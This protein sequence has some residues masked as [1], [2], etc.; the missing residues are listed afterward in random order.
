VVDNNPHVVEDHAPMVPPGT[1]VQV[2]PYTEVTELDDTPVCRKEAKAD[3]EDLTYSPPK[4]EARQRKPY[5]TTQHRVVN[6]LQDSYMINGDKNSFD[7]KEDEV[8]SIFY[9]LTK[10]KVL[11]KPTWCLISTTTPLKCTCTPSCAGTSIK[12]VLLLQ[13]DAVKQAS[14][15]FKQTTYELNMSISEYSLYLMKPQDFGEEIFRPPKSFTL[16]LTED[17]IVKMK[18]FLSHPVLRYYFTESA[19]MRV[20]QRRGFP[21]KNFVQDKSKIPEIHYFLTKWCGLW[22]GLV[23]LFGVSITYETLGSLFYETWVN[24]EVIDTYFET[25]QVRADVRNTINN[26]TMP[27]VVVFRSNFM[28]YLYM[29]N[30]SYNYDN[31][32]TWLRKKNVGDIKDIKTFIGP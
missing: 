27:R 9:E 21:T 19:G 1:P 2:H 5:T 14:L 24:D 3:V 28:F 10:Q 22:K 13:K 30:K 23:K 31:V 4:E 26:T 15:I 12:P 29:I 7:I 6:F 18:C 16:F 8:I 32:K 17:E 11:M 20:S 25:L